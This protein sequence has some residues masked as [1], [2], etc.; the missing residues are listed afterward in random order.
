[1]A[2]PGRATRLIGWS[3]DG[4][5]WVLFIAVYLITRN[6]RLAI[7]ALVAASIVALAVGLI[8]HRRFRPLPTITAGL[9]VLFGG[10]S[11][12]LNNPEIL[13]AKMTIVDG[14]F[15]AVLFAGL[16]LKKNP[17]KLFLGGAIPLS[18]KAWATLTIRYGSF[19]WACAAA[20]E[21][22]RRTQ[23]DHTWVMFKGAAIAAG[24]LFAVVQVP[25]LMKHGKPN[26]EVEPTPTDL[27]G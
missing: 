20:N 23:S 21:V 18:D 27:G 13:K 2:E 7:T 26:A 25:F 16:G 24:V 10:A 8:I 11:L 6:F 3:V 15:G 22:V 1:M 14:A 5:P 17:L 12:A 9:T 4:A 19:W